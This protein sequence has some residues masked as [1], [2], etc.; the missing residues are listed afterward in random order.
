M[1]R[2]VAVLAALLF[3]SLSSVGVA[4]AQDRPSVPPPSEGPTLNLPDDT[5]AQGNEFQQARR[6]CLEK[7]HMGGPSGWL[8]DATGGLLSEAFCL[9]KAS[10]DHP[11]AAFSTALSSVASTFWD[12]PVGKFAKAVMEGNI[13]AFSTVMTFWMSVPIPGLTGGDAMTGIRNITWEI[14]LVAFVV[15]MIVAAAKLAIARQQAVAEGADETAKMLT[16]TIFAA[17][18]LPTLVIIFHLTGDVFSTWVL[19]QASGG[20][21]GAKVTAIAWIDEKTGL[22]PVLALVLTG[23]GLLGSVSQL[24]ALLVREA[25]LA[26]VVGLAPV[27]AAQSATG[28]GR[29]SWATMMGFVVAALLFKPVASLFYVFAFWSSSSNVASAAVIGSVL[30][31]VAGLSL[32]SLMAAV[33]PVGGGGGGGAQQAAAMAGA[34]GAVLGSAAALGTRGGS[35]GVRAGGAGGGST[36]GGGG[37][38]GS[39][40]S[41]AASSY[42]GRFSSGKSSGGGAPGARSSAAAAGRSL[43]RVGSGVAGAVGA[44]TRTAASAAGALGRGAAVA[45]QAASQGAAAAANIAGG[46][47]GNY[48]GHIP[49]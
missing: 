34:T 9:D 46:A 16:R 30:L 24:I 8:D 41:G 39:P 35:G 4:A 6:E 20:D 33:G 1:K 10:T 47:V 45:G 26:I 32:P 12:D 2:I 40:A 27:A 23:L 3:F 18:L 36:G 17:G 7:D 29:Q 13:A 37:G 14:Q 28:T 48:H 38:K 5:G 42:G 22:G 15:G 19:Q 43:G 25:V 31:A 49:R 21:L 44:G 11:G